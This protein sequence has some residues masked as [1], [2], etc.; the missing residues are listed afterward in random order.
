MTTSSTPLAV[1]EPPAARL[2]GLE[3]ES[4]WKVIERVK[5]QPGGTGGCFSCAYIVEKDRRRAFLKALDYSKAEEIVAQTGVDLPTALQYL[6]QSYNFERNLLKTCAQKRMDRVV[7]AL[8]DGSIKVDGGVFGTVSYLIFEPA[9]G[10]VR[11][12][13]ALP[14]RVEL[15]W[16][17]RSLHHIATGLLQLHSA[18]V[19]HQDLKPSNVLVFNGKISKVSDLGSASIKETNCPRDDAAFAGDSTYAPPELLY[20]QRDNEWN[21]RRQA[22]DVYH[23]GSMVVFFFCGVGMTALILKNLP[24]D[25]LYSVWGGTYAQILP[26]VR[27]AFGLA[28]K[29]FEAN[30]PGEALRRSLREIVSQL[31]DPD[32]LLR[33]H[34]QNRVGVANPYSLERYVGLF[35]LLAQRAEAGILE[36]K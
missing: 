2:E 27:D 17:L 30:V 36:P 8:E 14:Q 9:D 35:N 6:I 19:A 4:G 11:K 3:L 34:P 22:C 1:P 26:E 23:L 16:I 31:C 21:R 13:L 18:K 29:E 12:H 24:P 32:P 10:D 5:I 20:G 28:L 33:G 25:R 7:T 15:A